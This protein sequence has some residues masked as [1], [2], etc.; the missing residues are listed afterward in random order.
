[1]NYMKKSDEYKKEDTKVV[2]KGESID[3][4]PE[5]LSKGEFI[6]LNK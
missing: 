3:K 5:E 6:N 2:I 4:N 1:M